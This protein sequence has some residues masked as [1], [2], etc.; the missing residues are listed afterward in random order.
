[1]CYYVQSAPEAV[2]ALEGACHS[3][4]REGGKGVN[5][6]KRERGRGWGRASQ[7][8]PRLPQHSIGHNS[9]ASIQDSL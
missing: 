4:E 9:L 7:T 5:T 2:N 1:M 6:V 3:L 8:A